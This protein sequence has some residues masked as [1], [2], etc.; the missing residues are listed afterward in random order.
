MVENKKNAVSGNFIAALI[1][2]I[3]FVIVGVIFWDRQNQR[4]VAR[5]MAVHSQLP[6]GDVWHNRQHFGQHIAPNIA[7]HLAQPRVFSFKQI[8]ETISPSVVNIEV[9]TD[10]VPNQQNVGPAPDPNAQG[11][12]PGDNAPWRPQFV[13]NPIET[14]AQPAQPQPMAFQ[15]P[16]VQPQAVQ[17]PAMQPQAVQQP[18]MQPQAVQQPAMQ[19]QAV[20]Q[21]AIQP[22][23]QN[24]RPR[25]MG[26]WGMGP[27]GF[28]VCPSCGTTV[29]HQAGVPSF[30]VNCPNCNTIM[31]REGAPSAS[32]PS[33]DQANPWAQQVQQPAVQQPAIQPQA[34]QQPAMLP[35]AVQ[36]PAIQPQAQNFQPRRI[37]GLGMGPDGY[38]VCPNCGTKV[39]HQA[40]VPTFTVHCPSCETIMMREGAQ[41]ANSPQN[42]ATPWT[43][44]VQ[45][46]Q[47]Q[48]RGGS[49]VIV[50]HEGYVLT[51][52]HVV[53]GARN[54]KV[55]ISS[56]QLTKTYPAQLIDESPKN[57]LAIIKIVPPAEEVFTAA[58]IGNSDTLSVGDKIL[59]IGGPYGLQQ[60]AT[61]G[62]VS[63]TRRSVTIGDIAFTDL[64]Q[65]DASINP[66][67]SGGPLVNAMGE[68]IGINTAIYSPTQS[69][70]GI[71]FSVPINRAITIFPEFIENIHAPE[72]GEREPLAALPNQTVPG[73]QWNQQ[74][75]RQ[76]AVPRGAGQNPWC[77]PGM[78]PV[79]NPAV[80]GPNPWCPPGAPGMG[81]Q[82]RWGIQAQTVNALIKNQVGSPVPFGAVI[83]RIDPQF[84]VPGL[85]KGDIVV[86]VDDQLIKDNFM[87]WTLM[88]AKAPNTEIK[89]TLFRNGEKIQLV[90]PATPWMATRAPGAPAAANGQGFQP[91]VE[92]GV[93]SVLGMVAE[94]LTPELARVHNISIGQEGVVITEAEGIAQTAGL[95]V[96]DIITEISNQP[97]KKV[98]DL[99]QVMSQADPQTGVELNIHRK[100]ERFTVTLKDVPE[101]PEP[102]PAPATPEP[103]EPPAAAEPA[104]PATIPLTGMLVGAEVEPG[105]INVL[106]MGAEELVP[107]LAAAYNI[108]N[109][110]EG[111]I[112]TETEAQAQTAGLLAG[113]LIMGIDNQ[114]VKKITDLIQIMN[115]ATPQTGVILDIYRK[116]ERFT[117]RLKG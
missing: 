14:P 55:T 44:Q 83:T 78:Q 26:G 15:Q 107:E 74:N 12:L 66:G 17:Q 16:A 37:G 53:K 117:V 5:D 94:D 110:V 91:E 58:P 28:L 62:I 101:A 65:T 73:P 112:I 92:P 96:G 10:P 71:G 82:N 116:G 103:P 27:D 35:Q 61:F 21:P 52:L 60:S 1:A 41:G 79:A 54:I 59:A 38:L 81:G 98:T 77:P 32:P 89:L 114:P 20:Q 113:D 86:R 34:V 22:Q 88:K 3:I 56:G 8:V 18:A 111:L 93:L 19:P 6:P 69:F 47:N 40:G 99:A 30:T 24:F 84:K 7:P 43:R 64:F 108:P 76:I 87:F 57:D 2:F 85:H 115:Q 36:Q 70:S 106:G 42:Q 68:V 39:P 102:P 49:G 67:S 9:D 23:A 80:A 33:L 75:V 31:M 29:P 51:N 4:E 45:I 72:V 95:L 109:G 100:G 105:A 97:V 46:P 25:R 50:H 63:N 13:A 11:A 48:G 104:D 90:I